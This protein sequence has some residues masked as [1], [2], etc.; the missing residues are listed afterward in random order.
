[1][2][3]SVVSGAPT[4]T[5]SATAASHVTGSPYPI[6][7][8]AGSTLVC[9]L[10]LRL[11]KRGLERHSGPADHHG[12]QREQGLRRRIAG[13]FGEL[14]RLRQRGLADKSHSLPTLSTT[15]TES[16]HVRVGGYPITASGATIRTTRSP[17]C[18]A[19]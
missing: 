9:Q 16:S 1:M 4:L 18:P 7:A 10:Q 15:A 2:N 12:E 13:A 14:Q 11:C 3:P 6:L 19:R 5:T 17:I 8:S